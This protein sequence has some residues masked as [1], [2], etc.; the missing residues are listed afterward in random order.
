MLALRE[1]AMRGQRMVR[2]DAVRAT[3]MAMPHEQVPHEVVP[4]P[5]EALGDAGAGQGV[6]P[7]PAPR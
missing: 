3:S 6:R 7:E 4:E 2:E 5:D 1:P